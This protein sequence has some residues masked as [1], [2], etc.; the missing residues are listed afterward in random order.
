[1]TFARMIGAAAVSALACVLPNMP[2]LAAT[3]VY[4]SNAE[5]GTIGAYRMDTATGELQPGARV[6]AAPLVMPMAVSPD[7]RFL[8]AAI[9]T[10]P[11]AFMT[12]SIDRGTGAARWLSTAPASSPTLAGTGTFR[13]V[14]RRYLV[15]VNRWA[16]WSV[17][18]KPLQV[19]PTGRNAHSRV[20]G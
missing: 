3:F 20:D 6:K 13:R 1:M 8:H 5:D 10:R 9:R 17:S 12:Y 18:E 7:R 2:T 14:V 16:G 11:F 19:I 15:S 4:V